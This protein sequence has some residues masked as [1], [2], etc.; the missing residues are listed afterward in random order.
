[1]LN[2]FTDLNQTVYVIPKNKIKFMIDYKIS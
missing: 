1:M 2:R